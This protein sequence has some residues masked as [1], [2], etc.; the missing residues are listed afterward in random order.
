MTRVKIFQRQTYKFLKTL[1][2]V[3]FN[4][5]LADIFHAYF[6]AV[7]GSCREASGESVLVY[8]T[9]FESRQDTLEKTLLIEGYSLNLK[10]ASVLADTVL[11]ID[12]TEKGT[13]ERYVQGAHYERHLYEDVDKQ[14]SLMLKPLGGADYHI[15]GMINFTHRIAPFTNWERSSQQKM[16]HRVSEIDVMSGS[17]EV[18]ERAE[19]ET[20]E[21]PVPDELEDADSQQGYT[22]EVHFITGLKHS[23]FF[24]NETED[25]VAYATL[26]MH[27]VS[28]RLQQLDPPIRIG[29]TVI[30]GLQTTPPYVK[31]TEDGSMI[32]YDTVDALS[33]EARKDEVKNMSD[34]VYMA[35]RLRLA[36]LDDKTKRYTRSIA[37][38]AGGFGTACKNRNV[39]VGLDYPDTF[40]GVQTAAH[41]I[42]HL[43][44]APH[45]GEGDAK[46]CGPRSTYLMSHYRKG[47]T[48]CAF[49][50]CTKEIIAKFLKKPGSAC[51][52]K[53]AQ[54]Q[55]IGLPNK[56]ANLP[57]DV[58][59]ADT[60][61]NKT[62]PK[63][64]YLSAT[65][66]K[67]DTQ[68]NECYFNCLVNYAKPPTRW[69]NRI[70]FAVDGTPCSKTEPRKIC[71]NMVCVD[72]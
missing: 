55:V 38:L 42:G 45:D 30:E 62:Y 60:Y 40:S 25:R 16:P 3:H 46:S 26:F 39:A 47:K 29:L 58:M 67:N 51:L 20:E 64:Q 1:N 48:I 11:L 50:T 41:E 66:I 10:K 32:V 19:T 33:E 65:Y 68:L 70:T 61:C 37:G 49:S 5:F 54:C 44:D 21:E 56:A 15:T 27:A 34:I 23:G 52:K 13:F 69:Q 59:D 72:P 53:R 28:L 14:A 7:L 31:L 4:M 35:S 43:L 24:R 12:V 2:E 71:K 57:G 8:P 18:V 22:L 6:F 9:V 17:Y 63:P 36:K